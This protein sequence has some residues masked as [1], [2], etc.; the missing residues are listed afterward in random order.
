MDI[1]PGDWVECIDVS[2]STDPRLPSL[3]IPCP[4][5]RGGVYQVAEVAAPVEGVSVVHLSS[6]S[7][8]WQPQAGWRPRHPRRYALARFKPV[9]RPKESDLLERLMEPGAYT[10]EDMGREFVRRMAEG[11]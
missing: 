9:H 1:G 8:A 11:A 2:P 5:R 7:P 3:C 4:L 6:S 10:Y